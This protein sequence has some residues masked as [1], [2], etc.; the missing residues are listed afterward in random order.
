MSSALSRYL[1]DFGAEPVQ[2]AVIMPSMSFDDEPSFMDIVEEAPPPVDIEVLRREAYEEGHA[3]ATSA[4]TEAHE[5]ELTATRAMHKQEIESLQ[6]EFHVAAGEKIAE[7]LRQISAS[8]AQAVSSGVASMLAPVMT[9][10]LTEI[11]IAELAELLTAAIIEGA[12][13]PITVTGP[14]PLFESLVSKLDEGNSELLSHVDAEDVDLSV[15]IG[16]S[17]LVTRIS[18]WAD[19]VRKVLT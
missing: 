3:A 8:I 2:P 4:L 6:S 15:T 12:A 17:V 16:D 19:G 1:K 9:E 14:L 18:A 10:A 5:T 7:Q 13:G 11:A